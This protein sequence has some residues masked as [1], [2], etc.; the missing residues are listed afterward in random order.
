MPLECTWEQSQFAQLYFCFKHST[1]QK[2][3][4]KKT[5]V[6]SLLAYSG[7]HAAL[8]RCWSTI[9]SPN[10]QKEGVSINTTSS[11]YRGSAYGSQG[12]FS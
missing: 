4:S 1:L 5:L 8:S 7:I 12:K 11:H 3:P 2:L 10:I 6:P 9:L